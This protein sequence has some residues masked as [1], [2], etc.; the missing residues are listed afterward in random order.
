MPVRGSLAFTRTRKGL[1]AFWVALFMLSIA[2]QYA[3][4]M[5]PQRALAAPLSG[6]VYTSIADGSDIDANI[7]DNKGDVYLTGGPCQGGS[8]L[9]DGDYYFEVDSPNGTL[10]S[11]DAIGNR[12]FTI[13][14]GFIVS[15]TGTH[16]THD[17]ACTSDPAI[18]LQLLPYA[19]T[20]NPGGEYK[21]TVATK[22]SVEACKDFD[23]A[24]TD[25]QICGSADQK[26]D[27]YKVGPSGSVKIVKV[28]DGGEVS[29]TFTFKVDCGT[30][31]VFED[32]KVTFPDPG[33]AT[34]GDIPAGAECTVT[35]TGMADA[36]DNFHWGT[37]TIDGSP[38]T[39]EGD[40]TVTVTATNHLIQD[41]GD[42]KITKVVTGGE[43]DATFT[44]HVDCGEAFTGDV[45]VK[46]GESVTKSD[47]PAGTECTIS[48]PDQPT[49][50]DGFKWN[51]PIISDSTV[52]IGKD[53]TVEVTV[54]NPLEVV[55]PPNTPSLGIA[56]S[57]NAPIVGGL[58]TAK[59]GD[60]V[61]YTLD[62]TVANGPVH[63]GIITDVLPA[64]VTYVNG[65]ASSDAQFTFVDFGVTTPGALTWKAATVASGGTL[66]YQ[67]TIAANAPDIGELINTATIDSDETG[68]DHDSSHVFV[69][70]PPLAE[71]SVPTPPQTDTVGS[72]ESTAS[73]SSMLLVLLALAGIA[74]AV[75]FVAPT[76]AAIRKRMR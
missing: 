49:P 13:A 59:V 2:L 7:Y 20:P 26:S 64:G 75:V 24:S 45:T 27:N 39:I 73:G 65:S 52:T 40:K 56:K 23:P 70:P 1:V 28:V 71:T 42:L 4:A 31:G 62:Y 17:V 9:P 54:T 55:P 29:G 25:F 30:D 63:N 44:I 16:V 69:A 3:A 60:T 50:P 8:H 38:A 68:P 34:I 32:V 41:V 76:P 5:A 35:E 58:P 6:A 22:D 21:L 19:D 66:T 57:N 36:P 51:D 10:L 14:G 12:L 61:T 43:S 47:L 74:L 11:S 67:V 18:T 53:S 33:S 48:E 72:T 15:T 46:A 37:V